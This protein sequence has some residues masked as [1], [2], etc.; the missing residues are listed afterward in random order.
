MPYVFQG[1][2]LAC[3]VTLVVTLLVPFPWGMVLSGL[4]GGG[5][6]YV[7]SILD[8]EDDER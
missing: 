8:A 4:L 3:A 7:G 5:L 6:T 2:I 1:F